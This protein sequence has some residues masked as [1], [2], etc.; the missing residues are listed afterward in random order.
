MHENIAR[1]NDAQD[2]ERAAVCAKLAEEIDG[3]LR[4]AESKLWH[5]GPVWFLDGNPIVG[6]WVRKIG[7]TLLFW[8]GQSFA[9]PGLEPEG[10]F[11]AAEKKYLTL[12]DVKVTVLRKW[13]RES[14]TIQW[15]YQNLVKRRGTLLKLGDW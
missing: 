14:R 1:Y 5:G 9:T 15:D 8:S 2:P 3:V 11:Q 12:G 4:E 13:L 10:K 6:Y 7:V